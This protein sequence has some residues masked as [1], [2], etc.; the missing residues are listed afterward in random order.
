[1]NS[2]HHRPLSKLTRDT[3][4][5]VVSNDADLERFR[6]HGEYRIPVRAVGHA[7]AQATLH[8]ICYL[9]LYQTTAI[10]DGI[11]G[12]IEL[13]GAIAERRI[14]TRREIVPEQPN[15]PAANECYHLLRVSPIQ[16]LERP[17]VAPA[18]RRFSFIRTSRE[19][20]LAASTLDDLPIVSAAE[21]RLWRELQTQ[22]IDVEPHL[23]SGEN[24]VMEPSIL[25]PG[26]RT[27]YT[28]PLYAPA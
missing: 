24:I 8:E 16:G 25:M 23:L 10:T 27:P 1:M 6:T 18:R 22:E 14:G 28:T 13:W 12:A 3:L 15:H 5:A 2:T 19:R 4:V 9:A 20:L 7:I 21:E 26:D 17:I 11:A